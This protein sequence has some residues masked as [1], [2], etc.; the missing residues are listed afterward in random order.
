MYLQLIVV[1]VAKVV[2]ISS[3]DAV[4]EI[5]LSVKN[6]FVIKVNKQSNFTESHF[7]ESHST[8]FFSSLL[9]LSV[10]LLSESLSVLVSL[11]PPSS[12][13]VESVQD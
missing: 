7:T 9:T 13:S 11:S 8:F 5:S 1:I 3:N 2:V 10:P 4:V 6:I 12:D